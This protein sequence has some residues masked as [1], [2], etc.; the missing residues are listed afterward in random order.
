MQTQEQ[1]TQNLQTNGQV[2]AYLLLTA[3]YVPELAFTELRPDITIFSNKLKRVILI[4]LTCPCEENMKASHNA[5]VIN[6]CH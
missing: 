5:K 6:T 1:T 4:E 3:I 2:M